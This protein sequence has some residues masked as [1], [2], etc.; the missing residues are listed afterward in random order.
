MA[1]TDTLQEGKVAPVDVTASEPAE[2]A[3]ISPAHQ[4]H[5]PTE[6]DQP[7]HRST[8]CAIADAP[9][10]KLSHY[11][12]QHEAKKAGEKSQA[13]GAAT[14][15]PSGREPPPPPSCERLAPP[16]QSRLPSGHGSGANQAT[17]GPARP[18]TG[19]LSPAGHAAAGWRRRRQH[20][21]AQ[22]CSPA[23]RKSRHGSAP[24]AAR[25]G[26]DGA[27]R[28]QIWAERRRQD[29]PQRHP[30][31]NDAAAVQPPARATTGNPA[32]TRSVAT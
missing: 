13:T 4:P 1:T 5:R 26:P 27:R 21:A 12:H 31:A 3:R 6:A 25:P 16:A 17:P 29:P 23:S 2:P 19:P 9:P 14:P 30:A 7:N 10:P 28:A 20:H 8:P 18:A 11:E 15:R 24:L 32:A 22:R